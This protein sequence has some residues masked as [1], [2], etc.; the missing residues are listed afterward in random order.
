[1]REHTLRTEAHAAIDTNT[2]GVSSSASVE[3][4]EVDF[5]DS[6]TSKLLVA[7]VHQNPE[8]TNGSESERPLTV[9]IG[10]LSEST[11]DSSSESSLVCLNSP[12]SD[13][14]QSTRGLEVEGVSIVNESINRATDLVSEND[15]ENTEA[16]PPKISRRT[17]LLIP[18]FN[19]TNSFT[20]PFVRVLRTTLQKLKKPKGGELLEEDEETQESESLVALQSGTS[21]E[22]LSTSSWMKRKGERCWE[23]VKKSLLNLKLFLWSVSKFN[24]IMVTLDANLIAYILGLS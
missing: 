6:D 10:R 8:A 7:E 14:L 19:R 20:L 15:D 5:D 11:F 13:V 1:M 3:E 17:S 22:F 23:S 16:K 24:S 18:Y 4:S 2:F 21:S 12:E 9:N